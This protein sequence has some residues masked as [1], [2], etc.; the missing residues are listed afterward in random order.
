MI[1]C[2]VLVPQLFWFKKIRT[3]AWLIF[4]LSLLINVGMW[5]ERFVII[6]TSLHRDFVPSSWSMYT[7]TVVEVGTLIGSFGLFFT[8]FLVFTRILP[9]ISIGE[10]KAVRSVGRHPPHAAPAGTSATEEVPA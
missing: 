1:S 6:V 2:N 7:P 5:F 4:P 10:V 3:S 8:L 9:M